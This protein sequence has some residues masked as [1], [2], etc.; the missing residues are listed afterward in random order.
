MAGRDPDRLALRALRAGIVSTL[1]QVA[2]N[3]FAIFVLIPLRSSSDTDRF[4][5]LNRA[6]YF[7]LTE[8]LSV[9]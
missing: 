6:V 1:L 7:Q 4:P 8:W 5:C 9:P 3:A 2:G